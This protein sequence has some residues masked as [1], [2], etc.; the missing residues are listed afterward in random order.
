[1][2]ALKRARSQA[3]AE[4]ETQ[5]IQQHTISVGE[6]WTRFHPTPKRAVLLIPGIGGSVLHATTN[7]GIASGLVEHV[8]TE[9]HEYDQNAT[10]SSVD[11]QEAE[12]VIVWV[13]SLQAE[14]TFKRF[15]LGRFDPKSGY[16]GS[17]INH[18]SGGAR[19]KWQLYSPKSRHGLYAIDTLAP[20]WFVKYELTYY[21]HGLIDKLKA[22]GYTEGAT[23]FGFGYDWRQVSSYWCLCVA[24]LACPT[25][26]Y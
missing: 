13:R 15:V 2:A 14:D 3:Q 19:K 1:V 23:L 17:L 20:H 25:C 12:D 5:R 9:V 6:A 8:H 11:L 21:Y 26:V 7:A 22:I 10:E 24:M 4:V 18:V 16:V